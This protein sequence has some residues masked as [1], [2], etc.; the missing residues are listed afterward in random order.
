MIN[1]PTI[2][3]DGPIVLNLFRG[4]FVIAME[5]LR[6]AGNAALLGIPGLWDADYNDMVVIIRATSQVP[7]PATAALL[8][9]GLLGGY[10]RRRK[11]AKA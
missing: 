11:Q 6:R 1:K 3:G 4:D 10:A 9:M 7:E 5:D 8:G 2:R